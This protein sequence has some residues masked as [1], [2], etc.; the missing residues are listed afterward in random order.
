MDTDT[1]LSLHRVF[2]WIT[3]VGNGVAGA[4]ALLSW[5][6]RALRGPLVWALAIA[7][8]TALLIQ[9]TLGVI[10]VSDETIVAPRFHM[11]YGFVG[12]L[13]VGLAYSY[14]I[15]MRGRLEMFYGIVGLFL[16]GVG[17]RAMLQV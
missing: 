6:V 1:L 9:V 14:R 2:A 7:A 17:I 15:S 16:M 5:R 11:F 4:Y 10:L 8:E 3:I 12:F 13:T